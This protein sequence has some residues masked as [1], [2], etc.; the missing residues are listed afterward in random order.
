MRVLNQTVHVAVRVHVYERVKLVRVT[1][2]SHACHT[3]LPLNLPPVC[4]VSGGIYNI[5]H[6]YMGYYTICKNWYKVKRLQH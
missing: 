3:H 1:R 5:A 6:L 2:V 4:T